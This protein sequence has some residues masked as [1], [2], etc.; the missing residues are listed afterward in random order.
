MLEEEED[1]KDERRPVRILQDSCFP[2]H[3]GKSSNREKGK[4]GT[5]TSNES[6]EDHRSDVENKRVEEG[7]ERED[8]QVR[9]ARR[10]RE[11]VKENVG[12]SSS[13]K[14]RSKTQY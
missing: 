4:E 11:E 3:F 12:Y 1:R 9:S 5:T 2:R 7:I 10:R 13:S 14:R 8:V 6:K